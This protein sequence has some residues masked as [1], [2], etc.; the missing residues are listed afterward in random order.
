MRQKN[1]TDDEV[2]GGREM[3]VMDRLRLSTSLLFYGKA[4]SEKKRMKQEQKTATD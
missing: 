4:K 3:L 1:D 2:D